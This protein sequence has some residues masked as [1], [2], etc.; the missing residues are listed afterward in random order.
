M[1]GK[2]DITP[3]RSITTA[4]GEDFVKERQS[5]TGS[6]FCFDLEMKVSKMKTEYTAALT[7]VVALNAGQKLIRCCRND[8]EIDPG[9][10]EK[11]CRIPMIVPQM[12]FPFIA[13]CQSKG[14]TVGRV[15]DCLSSRHDHTRCCRNH[16]VS[17]HCLPFCNAKGAVP[18]DMVKYAICVAEFDKYRL[19]F[20][21]YLTHNPSIRGDI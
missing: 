8:P 4:F 1:N 20:R 13:E 3:A 2:V 17:P 10:A 21:S 6:K 12:V 14:R 18:T 19:C 9:C 5:A 16:G 11:Y 7:S 15:W